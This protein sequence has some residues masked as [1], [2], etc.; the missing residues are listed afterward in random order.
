MR[1][2]RVDELQLL[3]HLHRRGIGHSDASAHDCRS[4]VFLLL[5]NHIQPAVPN[6]AVLVGAAEFHS[7]VLSLNHAVIPVFTVG[8]VGQKI[9]YGRVLMA[10]PVL[11]DEYN[12]CGIVNVS[13]DGRSRRN[14]H[15]D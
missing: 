13:R 8:G 4:R 10:I 15:C 14:R 11:V 6:G 5:G 1:A 2:R 3:Y 9:V 12:A 7:G